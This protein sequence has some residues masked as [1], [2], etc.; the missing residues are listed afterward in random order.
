MRIC[1]AGE[2][3]RRSVEQTLALARLMRAEGIPV[4]AVVV[5]VAGSPVGCVDSGEV[6]IAEPELC[7]DASALLDVATYVVGTGRGAVEAAMRKRWV[8]VPLAD[9]DLPALLTPA[10]WRTLARQNFSVRTRDPGGADPADLTPL[11][12]LLR[13]ARRAEGFLG[14]LST[15]LA[16]AFGPGGILARYQAL[17]SLDQKAPG[18]EPVGLLVNAGSFLVPYLRWRRGAAATRKGS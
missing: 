12:D 5:G 14:E 16:G 18:L 8:F 6:F 1:R 17:Y 7:V 11:K 10:N 15:A 9:G 4:R 2:H 13:D 3:H